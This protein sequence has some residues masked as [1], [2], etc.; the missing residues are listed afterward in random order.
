[1]PLKPFSK[2][3]GEN[4]R[5]WSEWC[6][7]TIVTPGDGTITEPQ[8]G[9][10]VVSNR[11]LR[12][13]AAF[14]VIGNPTAS[15]ADPSD[16]AAGADDSFLARRSGALQFITLLDTDIPGTI[17]RDSDVSTAIATHE[18]APDPHPQYTTAAELA[19]GITAHEAAGDPHTV[20]PLAAGTETIS[21]AWNFG[22]PPVLPTYTVA[23]VPSAATYARGLIYVSNETGGA[24]VAF[25][26]GTNWRRLTD[27]AI[28]S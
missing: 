11:A 9:D 3:P 20:Y 23:G 19:A 13:S 26:D 8:L 24:V 22:L 6:S 4:L 10:N 12:N 16:I 17:A 15:G 28:V 27:R 14:S 7:N 25:S 21:G 18:A 5:E 1:M 2:F